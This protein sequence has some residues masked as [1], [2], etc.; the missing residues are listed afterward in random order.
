MLGRYRTDR[1]MPGVH[2]SQKKGYFGSKGMFRTIL[3]WQKK[4][5][6]VM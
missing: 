1:I 2:Q 5:K 3:D 4:K 6:K